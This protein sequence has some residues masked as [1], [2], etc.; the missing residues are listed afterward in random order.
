ML[1]LC[2]QNGWVLLFFES[3]PKSNLGS[4]LTVGAID[5]GF[6]CTTSSMFCR[7]R[8]SDEQSKLKVTDLGSSK[9]VIIIYVYQ[10]LEIFWPMVWI[11][12][13]RDFKLIGFQNQSPFQNQHMHLKL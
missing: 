12:V 11:W 9:I 8:L 6:Q 3:L 4:P 7:V 10:I 13:G 5:M 2:K 1:H